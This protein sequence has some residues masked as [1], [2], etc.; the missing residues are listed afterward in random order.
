MCRLLSIFAILAAF[1][2]TACS[3]GEQPAK[4]PTTQTASASADSGKATAADAP[5]PPPKIKSPV[6]PAPKGVFRTNLGAEPPDLDPTH[7]ADIPSINVVQN[8]FEPLLRMNQDG[9]P[10]AGVA[11]EWTHSDDYREWTFKLRPDAKW[12]NG[13]P[14]VAGDFVYAIERILDRKNAAAMA[15]MVYN[16]LEGGKAYSD[17]DAPD[18]SMLGIKAVDDHTLTIRLTGPTPYFPSLVTHPAWF[19]LHR[20]TIERNGDQWSLKPE[21]YVSNGAFKVA[22]IHPK[23]KLVA[24]RNEFYHSRDEVHFDR[25][26]ILY[27]E[28]QNT[29]VA[30]YE[31]GD[32]DWTALIPNREAEQLMK[33]DDFSNVPMIGTYFVSFN[34]RKAP[35]D[36]VEVRKAFSAAINR[37]QLVERVIK[38]GEL[39]SS[40]YIPRGIAMHNGRDYRDLAPAF[41]DNSSY[42]ASVE[43]AKKHLAAAGYGAGKPLP[44]AEYIFN[45]AEIHV[46][47][48]QVLQTYWK[49]N[50][51][52]E[53]DLGQMEWGVLLG[54]IRSHDFQI[55]RSSWIGDYLDPMTFLEIFETG[56]AKNGVG[57]ANP[58]YD[59]LLAKIRTETDPDKRLGYIIEAE[60]LIVETDCIIAP[61]YEYNTP[62]MLRTNIK[63]VIQM[64]TAGTDFSRAWREGEK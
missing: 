50:L 40:G 59:G 14:L 32:L 3:G 42:A 43:T 60:R 16:Y 33:R 18:A 6:P 48:A 20:G 34:I 49:T 39:P 55:C 29:Q 24:A 52:A 47:I 7:A 37:R 5:A 61:L 57:Y 19:P 13:D 63:G 30:A 31:A 10:K 2:L 44:R 35:F 45:N 54:R 38:R 4:S 62:T 58:E 46:D 64:P 51:G 23:S 36:N 27:I 41:I 53:I 21:T 1:G 26:E 22:E 17:A 28:N 25:V 11:M 12:S 15:M 9:T 8:L 56:H